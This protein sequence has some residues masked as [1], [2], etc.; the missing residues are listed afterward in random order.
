MIMVSS[1]IETMRPLIPPMVTISSPICRFSRIL[2]SYFC[3]FFW[4]RKITSHITRTITPR[5]MI[6]PHVPIID[7]SV[8]IFSSNYTQT[9]I[10]LQ[11]FLYPFGKFGAVL[12][13]VFFETALI[14]RLPDLAHKVI[15]K[16]KIVHYHQP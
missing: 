9:A 8:I 1:L 7:T 15:I 12:P 5:Y 6:I 16:I 11:A 13:S 4:G 3:F 14:Q 2:C 10:R